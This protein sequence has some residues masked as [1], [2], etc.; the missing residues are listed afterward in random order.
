MDHGFS[1]SCAILGPM[2]ELL[3]EFF[4]KLFGPALDALFKRGRANPAMQQFGSSRG[5]EFR[6]KVDPLD[7]D[8]YETSFFGR[9]DVARDVLTGT[10]DNVHFTY[11]EHDRASGRGES[12]LVRSVVAFDTPG[13]Q[14]SDRKYSIDAWTLEK[15][16]GHMFL[17]DS[18]TKQPQKLE[19]IEEFLHSALAAYRKFQPSGR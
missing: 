17:W 8:L 12:A 10:L 4:D 2:V 19:D 5:F 11:F 9:F 7:L 1:H 3:L 15:S 13:S 14:S 6:E 18:H 16:A